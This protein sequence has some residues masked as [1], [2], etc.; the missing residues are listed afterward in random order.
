MHGE[1]VLDDNSLIDLSCL[2]VKSDR[3]ENVTF[4]FNLS[5]ATI[6]TYNVKQLHCKETT[7]DNEGFS[8]TCFWCEF[9]E[10]S[11]PYGCY[12]ELLING[13]VS[14][15]FTINETS[16]ESCMRLNVS[17]Y[18]KMAAYALNESGFRYHIPAYENHDPA[19]RSNTTDPEKM[20]NPNSAPMKRE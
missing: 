20:D 13:I 8:R 1:A 9:V 5:P 7:D 4:H 6:S 2:L 18:N 16:Q 11:I 19:C 15:N 3:L 14:E 12:V 10:G 17:T